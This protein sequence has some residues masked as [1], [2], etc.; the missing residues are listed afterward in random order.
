M[1]AIML[2]TCRS[3]RPLSSRFRRLT[4][5]NTCRPGKRR[6]VKTSRA[7]K[8][9]Q[10]Y[11]EGKGGGAGRAHI[12]RGCASCQAWTRHANVAQAKSTC[13]L[14]AGGSPSSED[15]RKATCAS[16]AAS[17]SHTMTE[18]WL[19][20]ASHPSEPFRAGNGRSPQNQSTR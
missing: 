18:R 7:M 8:A 6:N 16:S 10:A 11:S 3:A 17:P 15:A 13:L 5:S 19:S 4:D 9:L 14:E 1:L 20:C 2:C 12:Y